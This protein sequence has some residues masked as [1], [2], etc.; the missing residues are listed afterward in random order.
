M[1]NRSQIEL[2]E[3]K[4]MKAYQKPCGIFSTKKPSFFLFLSFFVCF[5]FCFMLMN[6]PV[7]RAQGIKDYN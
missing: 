5:F 3:K 6:N 4:T 1:Q 2:K 7:P